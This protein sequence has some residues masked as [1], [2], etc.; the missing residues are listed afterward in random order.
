PARRQG[1]PV[2][3]GAVE[4]CP[5]GFREPAGEAVEAGARTPLSLLAEARRNITAVGSREAGVDVPM[6]RLAGIPGVAAT[7]AELVS[8]KQAI[9]GHAAVAAEIEGVVGLIAEA[10][11]DCIRQELWRFLRRG[12]CTEIET[13]VL[14]PCAGWQQCDAN[15]QA[16]KAPHGQRS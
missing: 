14:R 10:D 15:H 12:R 16:G 2:G 13:V 1:Q 7:D 5:G 3:A 8:Q 4:G 6:K 9:A 11:R